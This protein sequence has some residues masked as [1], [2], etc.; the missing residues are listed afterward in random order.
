MEFKTHQSAQAACSKHYR[1]L[2]RILDDVLATLCAGDARQAIRQWGALERGLLQYLALEEQVTTANDC[3]PAALA[4]L[5]A[6]RDG[7]RQEVAGLG[8][9]IDLHRVTAPEAKAFFDRFR[10][11]A[12]RADTL[13]ASAAGERRDRKVPLLERMRRVVRQ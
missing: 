12:R 13:F 4:K 5:G 2:E 10:T 8:A 1:H 7:L 11:H 6:E 9:A 3:D